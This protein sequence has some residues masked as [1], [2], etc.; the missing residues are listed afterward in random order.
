VLD[1]CEAEGIGDFDLAFAYEALARGHAVA[2]DA[3]QAR[4]MTDRALAAAERIKKDEDRKIL[5]AD[6]ETIPGQARFW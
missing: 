5:L 4:A 2:G 3:S 6:L 1:I